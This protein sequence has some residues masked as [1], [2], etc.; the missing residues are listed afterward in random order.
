[1]KSFSFLI[2]LGLAVSFAC[3]S[4]SGEEDSRGP[5]EGTAASE[6][7]DQA[8]T[9]RS[10]KKK[11]RTGKVVKKKRAEPGRK[12]S[13]ATEAPTNIRLHASIHGAPGGKVLL[14]KKPAKV[15]VHP[16]FFYRESGKKPEGAV[17]SAHI[18]VEPNDTGEV[19]VGIFEA[20]A[21][22]A[23]SQWRSAVFMAAF[24]S[25]QT[26]GRLLTDFQFSVHCGGHVDGPS[27]GALMS[28]GI[29]AALT[30]AKA[31]ERATMTGTINPDGTIGPVNGI[32]Q[33]FRAALKKGKTLL[34]YPVGQQISEDLATRQKIDLEKLAGD[35]GAKAREIKDIFDAYSLLTGKAL[36]RPIP[37][38]ESE[39]GLSPKVSR[40]VLHTTNYLL[41]HAAKELKIL[42]SAGVKN[43]RLL[44]LSRKA[45]TKANS[46]MLLLKLDHVSAALQRSVEAAVLS[47]IASDSAALERLAA[48]GDINGLM[49]H[50]DRLE[51]TTRSLDVVAQKLSKN[52]PR[53]INEFT[54]MLFAYSYIVDAIAAS[55]AGSKHHKAAKIYY[56]KLRAGGGKAASPARFRAL[57]QSVTRGAMYFSISRILATAGTRI[58]QISAFGGGDKIDINRVK[59]HR[60]TQMYSSAAVT[61]LNYFDSIVV[62]PM[63]R[64]A[65]K[66][67]ESTRETLM[68]KHF[69]YL[70]ANMSLQMGDMVRQKLSNNIQAGMVLLASSLASYLTTSMLVA[71]EYSLGVS[72][73]RNFEPVRLQAGRAF[74]VMLTA[75]ERRAREHAAAAKSA[76][77]VIPV[78]AKMAYLA[79]RAYAQSK[80]LEDRLQALSLFWTSSTVSQLAVSIR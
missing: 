60:L 12:A 62:E 48:K 1:M 61:N 33:K 41:E 52:H 54:G 39:M 18:R 55:T 72:R 43:E 4:G 37:V 66:S 20:F 68:E 32:P 27:A 71:E 67:T 59:L 34:G 77:G 13:L 80:S 14:A 70:M 17:G 6:K 3:N 73:N 63:A 40:A 74:A 44:Q 31:N 79:A 76:A 35:S 21:G 8:L 57:V 30:G 64:S 29:L 46:A 38:D 45:A 2:F 53:T 22:G 78:G 19:S 69:S 15:L 7:K 5:D 24:L 10:E 23:G 28:A 36:P 65:N 26:L 58:A 75:A 25:S 9:K 16:L 50:F 11:R 56:S 47:T 49:T 51:K 42:R